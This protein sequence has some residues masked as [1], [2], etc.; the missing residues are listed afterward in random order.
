MISGYYNTWLQL[1]QSILPQLIPYYN[2]QNPSINSNL[3]IPKSIIQIHQ[4]FRDNR[5]HT[6]H[7]NRLVIISATYTAFRI[8]CIV[9][10]YNCIRDRFV[11]TDDICMH[12][13]PSVSRSRASGVEPSRW[14]GA[15]FA[16]RFKI[17]IEFGV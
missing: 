6:S 3:P 8:V 17:Q 16:L 12:I 4:I 11:G 9:C 5:Q 15:I 2:H 13:R 10:A 7:T 14:V 1:R